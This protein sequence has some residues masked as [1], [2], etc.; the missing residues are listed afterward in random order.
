MEGANQFLKVVLWCHTHCRNL[1][2]EA[3]V[4][5]LP[6]PAATCW[7]EAVE[8][9]VWGVVGVVLYIGFPLLPDPDRWI[10]NE[11]E[12]VN[13]GMSLIKK[14]RKD[15]KVKSIL[16]KDSEFWIF[17]G[18]EGGLESWLVQLRGSG[19]HVLVDV[20]KKVSWRRRQ[21][22]GILGST[23]SSGGSQGRREYSSSVKISERQFQESPLY[24]TLREKSEWGCW[25]NNNWIMKVLLTL[26][27]VMEVE[28]KF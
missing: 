17:R 10:R 26:S 9:V 3:Q 19:P 7:G 14:T 21:K 8:M 25:L 28:S 5:V 18:L 6:P 2:L 1:C 12:A 15:K 4:Y 13:W 20:A 23:S 11:E 16:K 27:R 22:E 24:L